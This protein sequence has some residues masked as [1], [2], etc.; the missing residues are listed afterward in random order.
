MIL[1]ELI[2]C[3]SNLI[4]AVKTVR[5]SLLYSGLLTSDNGLIN[6]YNETQKIYRVPHVFMYDSFCK[7]LRRVGSQPS[8]YLK[9]LLKQR[10]CHDGDFEIFE[11]SQTQ[12]N[13]YVNWYYY[14]IR[15]YRHCIFTAN[16]PLKAPGRFKRPVDRAFTKTLF[17]RI[18]PTLHSAWQ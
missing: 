6:I 18:K 9:W 15:W 4:I 16:L 14:C 10:G 1:L 13:Q 3:N 11:W 17:L 8:P 7:Q 5:Y 12:R 2:P